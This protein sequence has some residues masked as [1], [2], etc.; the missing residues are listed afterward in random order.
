MNKHSNEVILQHILLLVLHSCT[1]LP[2]QCNIL[3]SNIYNI[4]LNIICL[5]IVGLRPFGWLDMFLLYYYDIA[6]TLLVGLI[7]CSLLAFCISISI[8]K[9][10]IYIQKTRKAKRFMS[11][12]PLTVSSVMTLSTCAC[13]WIQHWGYNCL[14]GVETI[15]AIHFQSDCVPSFLYLTLMVQVSLLI[16]P[17]IFISV[18]Y[19]HLESQWPSLRTFFAAPLLLL[20]MMMLHSPHIRSIKVYLQYA[21]Y[22][23]T[24]AER[25]RER[26]K[27]R[28]G[29]DE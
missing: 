26:E 3:W 11:V 14:V 10:S 4:C 9:L 21:V 20:L 24:D 8:C 1:R 5:N 12:M 6:G 17:L 15:E 16:C 27:E 25:E 29:G 7:C 13:D 23:L 18:L 2:N 19:C 28:E 22:H